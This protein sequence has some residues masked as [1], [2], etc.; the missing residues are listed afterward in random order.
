LTKTA[1][2]CAVDKWWTPLL[3]IIGAGAFLVGF[4]AGARIVASVLIRR[5]LRL[6]AERRAI[7]EGWAWLNR[8]YGVHKPAWLAAFGDS[9]C[10]DSFPCDGR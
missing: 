4:F 1:G 2:G 6:A 3:L 10:D 5:E 9:A 7:N 8:R